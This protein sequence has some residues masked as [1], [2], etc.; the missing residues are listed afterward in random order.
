MADR[1]R[2]DTWWIASDGKWYPPTLQPDT[3]VEP[4]AHSKPSTSLDARTAVPGVLTRVVTAAL[5]ATSLA[6]V[7]A[8]IFGL[9]FGSTLRVASSSEQGRA[10]AEEVF[11]GWSSFALFALL[12]TGVI[13]LVWIFQTSKAFDERGATGRRWRGAWTIGSWFVP[14]ASFILP[15][16]VFNE[17]EKIAQVPSGDINVGEQ[18]KSEARSGIGDL[19][20]LLWVAGLFML[21]TTQ[22]FLTDPAI[23]PGTIAMASS[24]SGIAHV[25]L[26]AAGV[27]FIVVIR[28]IE[29]A[30]RAGGLAQ[31]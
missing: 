9:R 25:V 3:S 16:L 5:A 22:V 27:V 18:W 20:W 31:R 19:W 6:F 15:K 17:L 24:L 26:A 8:G 2:D 23:D 29:S 30:S 11:L 13:V 1:P 21:Q 10:S 14:L 12:V 7:V 28:R 4:A